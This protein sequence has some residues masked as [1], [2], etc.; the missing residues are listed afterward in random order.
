MTVL[1]H[2]EVARALRTEDERLIADIL[3]T[4]ASAEEFDHARTW[5]ANE[6]AQINEGEA[7]VSGPV[8]RLMELMEAAEAAR[9]QDD[10]GPS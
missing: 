8:A 2:D 1:T 10:L 6:E 3:A 9:R 7:L 4:G 5:L